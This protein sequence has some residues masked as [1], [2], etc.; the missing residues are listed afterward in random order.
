MGDVYQSLWMG[1]PGETVEEEARAA[2]KGSL[3]E[4]KRGLPVG[5]KGGRGD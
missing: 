4:V 2:P 1:T 3:E 5:R